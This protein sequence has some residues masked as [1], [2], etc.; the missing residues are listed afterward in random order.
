MPPRD[1]TGSL[2]A[3]AEERFYRYHGEARDLLTN[4]RGLG[5]R[6]Q[7]QDAATDLTALAQTV[8]AM[9]GVAQELR[10]LTMLAEER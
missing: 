4:A 7:W 3:G 2:R 5:D 10:L 8:A 9:A 6:G 1:R